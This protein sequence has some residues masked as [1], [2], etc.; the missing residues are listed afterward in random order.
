MVT[1]RQKSKM[2]KIFYFGNSFPFFLFSFFLMTM[3]YFPPK[4]G[5]CPCNRIQRAYKN[6]QSKGLSPF[7]CAQLSLQWRAGAVCP[8]AMRISSSPLFCLPWRWGLQPAWDVQWGGWRWTAFTWLARCG[9]K[10]S[11]IPLSVFQRRNPRAVKSWGIFLIKITPTNE[12]VQLAKLDCSCSNRVQLKEKKPSKLQGRCSQP[13]LQG[14]TSP[15][16]IIKHWRGK[17]ETEPIL[18][19]SSMLS[20]LIQWLPRFSSASFHPYSPN[21][22]TGMEIPG[23]LQLL[24]GSSF[25]KPALPRTVPFNSRWWLFC[26]AKQN[27]FLAK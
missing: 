11:T 6:E 2:G 7:T 14:K 13:R 5:T 12:S 21:L 27:T 22:Q 23:R 4:N 3:S 17:S 24:M 15:L 25:V 26:F 18:L 19:Q 1:P 16:V 10:L 9:C 20:S 8:F